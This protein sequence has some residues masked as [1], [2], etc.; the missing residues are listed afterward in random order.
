MQ[1]IS[2]LGS[3]LK[4]WPVSRTR[5]LKSGPTRAPQARPS[6]AG[7]VSS[8]CM[9]SRG[10]SPEGPPGPLI[11]M[12]ASAEILSAHSF[13]YLAP[14]SAV[15]AT[16][17]RPVLSGTAGAR[18]HIRQPSRSLRGRHR[19]MPETRWWWSPSAPSGSPR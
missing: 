5:S 8:G 15:T 4:S 11:L 9:G 12:S 7:A 17:P 6:R 18:G 19:M 1:A 3:K 2:Q 10:G 13:V 16:A 14:G